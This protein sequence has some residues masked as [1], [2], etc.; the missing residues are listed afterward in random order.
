MY[1]IYFKQ[2]LKMLKQNK[3]ISIITIIGTALAI[4][5]IMVIIVTESIRNI[6]VAPEVNRDRTMYMRYE[7]KDRKDGDG[8]Q[9]NGRISYEVYSKCLADFKT[10]EM[11]V[12]ISD[13]LDKSMVSVAEKDAEVKDLSVKKTN[14]DFWKIMSFSFIG[15]KPFSEEDFQ[16]G[17][18]KAVLSK[19]AEEE[20]FGKDSGIGKTINI[21]SRPYEVVGIVKNVSPVFDYAYSEVYIPYTSQADYEQNAWFRILFLAKD[22][23]DFEAISEEVR[24]AERK[25]NSIDPVHNV[26]FL[27]PYNHAVNLL[28]VTNKEPDVKAKVL[29]AIVIL[30]VLLI[31]PAINLSSFSMSRMKKRIEEIGV[32]KAFGAKQHVI[33][34]QVLYE[35]FV[36]SLIGGVL[37]LILS[38]VIVVWLKQ[39]LLGIESG[40][41]L[42]VE[43]FVSRPVFI[44]V[45][46][47]CLILNL[48][49]AGIPAYRAS[50]THIV[51][52]LNRKIL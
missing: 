3:F 5:M 44:G 22:K 41:S 51:D 6:S 27:G 12:L 35:N 46:I 20:I 24:A 2:S 4:M 19:K 11:T 15:G 47:V 29:N 31:V 45:F 50:K 21:Q 43:T 13:D 40:A 25:Y 16:S 37:G 52:S 7:L 34:I 38:Y 14:A 9:H 48:L 30:M 23:G 17:L 33:L 28:N 32:R 36:T 10:P 8:W 39:W 49:S 26:K 42:P 18:K 1:K